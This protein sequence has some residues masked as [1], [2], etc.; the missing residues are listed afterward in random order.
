MSRSV[1]RGWQAAPAAAV[2]GTAA[3]F[4]A[5][6]SLARLVGPALFLDRESSWAVPRLALA[7]G[8]AFLS[9]AAGAAAGGLFL[10]WSR[11]SSAAND[12]EPL[13]LRASTLAALFAASL[14]LG[15]CVRF[16]RL[17]ELPFPT[18]H[19]DL[20][21]APKALALESG[22]RDFR[23]SIRPV[24]DGKGQATGTVGVLYLEAYRMALAACG[25]NVFGV[26]LLSALGG[27]L[28]IVT[29]AALARALLPRG[30]AA[31]AALVLAGLRW[32]LILSRWSWNMIVLAPILDVAALCAIAARRRR[33]LTA[34]AA[35][36]LLAGVGAHVYL[37]AWIGL[38]AV[39]LLVAWP[40]GGGASRGSLASRAA[41]ASA[42]FAGFLLASAPLF[43][44]REG[45]ETPYFARS[46][47]H[48]VIVEM[49]QKGSAAPLMGAVADAL[50][51]PWLL[52]DPEPR[53]DIPGR[54]RL[55]FVVG[56]ALAAALARALLRPGSDLSAYLLANAAAALAASAV[57][58]EEFSPNGSRF[59]YLTSALAV[60]AAAGLLWLVSLVNPDWRRAATWIAVGL[61]A[62]AGVL[63]A[64]DLVLWADLRSTFDRFIGQETLVGRAAMRWDRY[65]QVR[66]D[67]A[68]LY[69]PLVVDTIRR[70]RVA[71]RAEA[72]GP[73]PAA[74]HA[75]Q[76]FRFLSPGSSAPEGERVVEHVRDAW[77]REWAVVVGSRR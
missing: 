57:W 33:S 3:A 19:D 71:P 72:A 15:A 42:A 56:I 49:R 64:R 9:A 69:S 20:L 60:G 40:E 65:G 77:G 13:P 73:G 39:L 53:H 30:G 11:T 41:L 48:N 2:V 75:R 54:K 31:L 32:H 6:V 28:S 21:L 26:R 1:A 46:S 35:A 43:L 24:T 67:F 14:V 55:P 61:V 52:P 8:L 47:R 58:G 74:G 4:V 45:R 59:G 27:L 63:G 10:A 44:L 18:W 37:S 76:V 29:A 70:L 68:G 62:I 7:L 36:G 25:T 16:A 23:D 50:M 51:A 66:L 38:C 12:L 17:D 5:A 34:A 22:L